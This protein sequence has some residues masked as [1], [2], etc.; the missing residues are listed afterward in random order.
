MTPD[1]KKHVPV[2]RRT[3][4]DGHPLKLGDQVNVRYVGLGGQ[5][6]N[7]SGH[8]VTWLENDGVLLLLSNGK[9]IRTGP[10]GG[11]KGLV[12]LG[13]LTWIS[14]GTKLQSWIV[15]VDQAGDDAPDETP[16]RARSSKRDRA[17]A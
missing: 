12:W 2:L 11:K 1:H 10:V 17:R 8:L 3:D 15:K 14:G 5:M 9:T 7:H 13:R 6:V 16:K 4:G